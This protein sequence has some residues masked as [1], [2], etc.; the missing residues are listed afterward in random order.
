VEALGRTGPTIDPGSTPFGDGRLRVI[1]G[2]YSLER[3]IGRGGMGA[4]WL[5]TDE[6]LGRHVALKRIGLL[7]SADSTDLERAEREAR[8]AA[9]LEHPNVVAVFNL[10][11]DE[12]TDDRWLVL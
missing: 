8:L 10:V 7:P 6:V 4:V 3:V 12:S 2:R 1:A 5:A 11:A 9:Q